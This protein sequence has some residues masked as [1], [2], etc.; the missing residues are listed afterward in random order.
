MP[1][2]V[3]EDV[4]VRR[5]R[6]APYVADE[7]Q[8]VFFSEFYADFEKG[9]GLNGT[10]PAQDIDPTATLAWSDDRGHTYTTPKAKPL[11]RMGQ[12]K[13][14]VIWRRL[15]KGRSRIFELVTYARVKIAITD[16]YLELTMGRH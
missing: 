6:R 3:I 13:T 14:R 4:T 10:T 15:G 11:G 7:N 12:Y 2:P 5:M 1:D 16:A 9:V 8:R